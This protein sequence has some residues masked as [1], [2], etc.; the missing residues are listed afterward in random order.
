MEEVRRRNNKEEEFQN[1]E[2]V[3]QRFIRANG[4]T[5]IPKL[6][7]QPTQGTLW[8]SGMGL[9]VVGIRSL[10]SYEAVVT[11]EGLC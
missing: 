1:A 2:Q 9:S 11:A 8:L 5:L 3:Q 4:E 6:S 7:I 10:A